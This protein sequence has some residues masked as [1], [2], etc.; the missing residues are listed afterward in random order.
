M[1]HIVRIIGMLRK[2]CT[3]YSIFSTDYVSKIPTLKSG[4]ILHQNQ[5]CTD[6]FG[7]AINLYWFKSIIYGHE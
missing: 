7:L 5:V 6:S 1:N 3:K 2:F 4:L